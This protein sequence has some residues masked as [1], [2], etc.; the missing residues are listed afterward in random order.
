VDS[1]ALDL[2]RYHHQLQPYRERFGR[3]SILVILYDDWKSNPRNS[4]ERVC[5]HL[6]IDADA[7]PETRTVHSSA[8][9]YRSRLIL[10][11]LERRGLRKSEMHQGNVLAHLN[12]LPAD[13]RA[14]LESA[15]ESRY[16]L[17]PA[18]AEGVRAALADEMS[19]LSATYGIDVARWGFCAPKRSSAE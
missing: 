5:A 8:F 4:M 3:N 10:G 16:R 6:G 19:L 1:Y 17:S 15:V 18:Q 2:C 13:L 14:D 9:H 7:I 11:E 12:E